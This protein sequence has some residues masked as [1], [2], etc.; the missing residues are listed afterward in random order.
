MKKVLIACISLFLC[1]PIFAE[2]FYKMSQK[3]YLDLC[4]EIS[5]TK[6]T[7]QLEGNTGYY[8]KML[9]LER[10]QCKLERYDTES[11][12]TKDMQTECNHEW[13]KSETVTWNTYYYYWEGTPNRDKQVMGYFYKCKKCGIGMGISK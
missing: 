3:D 2:V 9:I 10:I 4:S 1:S 13:E 5:A 11:S 7:W 6:T 8:C 12:F